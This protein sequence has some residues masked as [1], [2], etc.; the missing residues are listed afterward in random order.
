MTTNS[1]V[2]KEFPSDDLV[3][4]LDRRL[5]EQGIAGKPVE[6]VVEYARDGW[7]MLALPSDLVTQFSGAAA[8]MRTVEEL[9]ME[10]RRRLTDDG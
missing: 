1:A 5:K 6:T 3:R 9:A 8:D 7:E 2:L 4:E 10:L